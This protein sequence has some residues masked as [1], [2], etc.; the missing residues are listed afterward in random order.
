MVRSVYEQA[1][2][3]V[4]DLHVDTDDERIMRE[5]EGFGGK[6]VMTSANHNS[7]TNR[8]LEACRTITR[9]CGHAFD[10]ILNI[11]G[12]KPTC[13]IRNRSMT[14]LNYYKQDVYRYN[15]APFWHLVHYT[16]RLAFMNSGS[17]AG[18]FV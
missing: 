2:Q 3:S 7:G 10:V 13:S 11:Q 4:R 5:V 8:C 18:K 16:W 12:D 6:A 17:I 14:Y 9:Y 1:S 15:S